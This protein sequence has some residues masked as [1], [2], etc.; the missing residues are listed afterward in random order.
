MTYTVLARRYRSQSFDTVVGQEP[1][2]R[3]LTN[4]IASNR[5]AHAY[6]FTG[7][8]GVGKTSMARLFARALNA[9][10]TIEGVPKPDDDFPDLDVQQR[11][12]DQIMTGEDLNVVEIDGASNRGIDD[13]RQLIANAS[14]TPSSNARY[15]I[16]IIDEVHQLTKDAFNA[17]LKVMEE[18]PSHVKFILCTTEPHKVLPTIQ[19]RCQRF[20]FRNIPTAEIAEHLKE[21]LAAE[22]IE[23]DEPAVWRMAR[24]ANGSMRDGLSLL[25]RLMATGESP[26]TAELLDQMLGLPPAELIGAL[27][28]ALA[29]GDIKAALEREND[30]LT[31][32]IA[33]DQL[34]EVLIDHLRQLM[35]INACGKDS[36]L[37]ELADEVRDDAAAQ[38]VKFDAAGLVH[39]IA[40]CEN[41]SRH[42][43]SAASPRALLD[44]LIVRLALAE[45]MA[46]VTAV[47][48]G[49]RSASPATAS[50]AGDSKKKAIAPPADRPSPR[51]HTPAS[52]PSVS[53]AAPTVQSI[54][55]TDVRAVWS[56]VLRCVAEKRA[57]SWMKSFELT[58]IDGRTAWIRSTVGRDMTKFVTDR[59]RGQIAALLQSIVGDKLDIR[60]EKTSS[61]SGDA[62]P[63][64]NLSETQPQKRLTHNDAMDLPL[65]KQVMDIFD[66]QIVNVREEESGDREK[67][68]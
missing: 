24:L 48:S 51:P 43:R 15:K 9:P 27:V 64:E 2:A 35:L 14:L 60:V 13:A 12:A 61:A 55:P 63:Q 32:G 53:P 62:S 57:L 23:A 38:A 68:A 28:D 25:D 42:S 18:P 31:R 17:L 44:A 37:V 21:V 34:I 65:V 11:M 29:E 20:D 45:K 59:Q 5:V 49:N 52:T 56:E 3:T 54:D 67:P 22:K 30:L 1:I 41:V 19:S 66:A 33:Q 6:L 10:D 46:D 16:Y 39:M 47:L 26:L 40:L 8:R 4:A 50:A 36:E 58:R 7:T